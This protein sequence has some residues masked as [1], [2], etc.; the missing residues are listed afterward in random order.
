M[1][2]RIDKVADRAG[3]PISN[4]PLSASAT[5]IEVADIAADIGQFSDPLSQGYDAVI[6]H[7][8]T[9][10][11]VL[12]A[13]R[14]GLAEPVRVTGIDVGAQTLTIVRGGSPLNMNLSGEYWIA[15]V[16]GANIFEQI[17]DRIPDLVGGELVR[18]INLE[19]ADVRAD[20]ARFAGTPHF[21]VT[22]SDYGA[23]GDGSTDDTV[24]VAAA[25]D[26]CVA[27]GGGVVYFPQGNYNLL[28][29]PTAGDS[30]A[31]NVTLL[32]DG[33]GSIITGVAGDDFVSVVDEMQVFSLSFS[34]WNNV[35]NMDGNTGT[36]AAFDVVG[37]K[38][39][40]C[41]RA[42]NWDTPGGS[43]G[44]NRIRICN[45]RVLDCTD[46]AFAIG[47]D[48]TGAG[49]G[50]ESLDIGDNYIDGGSSST[51]IMAIAVGREVITSVSVRQ[52][53]WK[54]ISIRNNR[55]FNVDGDTVEGVGIAVFGDHVDVSDNAIDGVA[56][57]GTTPLE[58]SG[59]KAGIR[60]GSICRNKISNVSGS[61]DW[62]NGI[63]LFGTGQANGSP[64]LPYC[65]N[66]AV[67]GNVVE[68][69]GV[70]INGFV[71]SIRWSASEI[72]FS[73][74]SGF[75]AARLFTNNNSGATDVNNIVV[76]DNVLR[77]PT[78]FTFGVE[79]NLVAGTGNRWIVTNNIIDSPVASGVGVCFQGVM[80]EIQISGN[81]VK[82]TQD[83][84]K[85]R[86]AA[87]LTHVEIFDNTIDGAT[88]GIDLATTGTAPD[89]VSVRNNVFKG[90]TNDINVS[91]LTPTN[92]R[93][94]LSEVEDSRAQLHHETGDFRVGDGAW[95]SPAQLMLGT[96][97]FWFDG[98][99]DL[100]I[101]AGVP[102]SSLDGTILGTQS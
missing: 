36:I 69:D 29:W 68:F 87:A 41:V 55:I 42:V 14:A 19:M 53:K 51:M 31:A 79:C 15:Q 89:E 101:K 66:V 17:D 24:A 2:D 88:D 85:L 38:F 45:N 46:I 32:G 81:Q 63:S 30:Y 12:D 49:N 90:V 4:A 95:N 62:N 50:W 3:C 7:R 34:G 67:L 18:N 70:V 61:V 75:E 33:V 13:Q 82:V 96:R 72:T 11:S 44:F 48:L 92:Y 73:G 35:F 16:V 86:G 27:A 22:H 64:I 94:I 77:S 93:T 8:A 91:G 28:T 76:S 5:V 97:R 39:S 54:N 60:Y 25:I 26:A 99:G 58:N 100:R 59:I 71:C 80:N 84:V 52:A 21:D 6:W 56:G 65:H 20:N 78:I 74:N 57:D 83:G 98:T 10:A 40:D 9:H 102:A 47:Y 43:A 1:T 23:T 37:C